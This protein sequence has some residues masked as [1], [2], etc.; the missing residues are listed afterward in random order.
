[1]CENHDQNEN[2]WWSYFLINVNVNF[3]LFL[4]FHFFPELGALN[5]SVAEPHYFEAAPVPGIK[6]DTA[7]VP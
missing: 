7:P 4:F 3:H 5:S 2:I 1:V 6:N